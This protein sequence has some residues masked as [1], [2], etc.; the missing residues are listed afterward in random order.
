MYT[1]EHMRLR[2]WGY[3][4][5]C[6]VLCATAYAQVPLADERAIA[7][8]WE[9]H[10]ANGVHG[11]FIS[12][13][14]PLTRGAGDNATAWQNESIRVY[15]RLN[16][17]ATHSGYFS[18][19]HSDSGGSAVFDGKRLS[20]ELSRRLSPPHLPPFSLEAVL[21]PGGTRWSGK[22]SLCEPPGG[23]VLERPKPG[24][25]VV[26]SALAGNWERQP[27]PNR[28][29]IV[30][31][32][33]HILQS[34]DGTKSAFQEIVS[35]A[36][37]IQELSFTSPAGNTVVLRTIGSRTQ[38]F[39]GTLS[40]DGSMLTGRWIDEGGTGVFGLDNEGRVIMPPDI[41]AVYKRR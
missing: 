25:D 24:P 5:I 19:G 37:V 40:A 13:H 41:P 1:V 6:F 16:I 38:R 10:D 22:W 15:Q 4:L 3:F 27:D 21:E 9:C 34:A 12:V 33:L 23:T 28:P 8:P 32:F 30:G 29:N 11:I 7:G 20:I 2:T 18:V 31:E 39:E 14:T 36:H 35:A 26:I 17:G